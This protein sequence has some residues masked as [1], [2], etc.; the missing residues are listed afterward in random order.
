M[1]DKITRSTLFK[2]HTLVQYEGGGYEGCFWEWNFA[3][4]TP[5][6]QFVNLASSGCN[7]CETLEKLE[8]YYQRPWRKMQNTFFL[9]DLNDKKS[10]TEVPNELN[11]DHL[12]GVANKLKE[13]GYPID[14]QPEC[15]ECESRFSIEGA[16]PNSLGGDG[17]IHMSH[18][19]IICQECQESYTCCD[20]GEYAGSDGM[21]KGSSSCKYC[22]DKGDD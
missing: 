14:F 6:S 11:V 4:I 12:I 9:Y 1:N 13:A 20:C 15:S 17:G 10:L 21:T 3:Y 5:D 7:G 19:E 8:A 22:D 18:R 16:S 2:P